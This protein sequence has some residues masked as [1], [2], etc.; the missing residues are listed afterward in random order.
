MPT[1]PSSP[2]S[3]DAWLSR[4]DTVALPIPVEQHDA[5]RRLLGDNR[6]SMREIAN[7][8]QDSAVLTLALLREANRSNASLAEPAES[9]EVALTRLG[10]Q[11]AEQVLQRLPAVKEPEIPAALRQILL[12]S[13]HASQQASGLFGA[14]LARLWQE[15]HG[16]SLLFL[17]PA[18]ALL[19]AQPEFFGRWEQ[20]VLTKGE[21]A[22]TVERELLG[23][24]LLQLCLALARRWKLPE[25][26]VEGYRALAD[27]RRM[28]VRAL[29]VAHDN[30]HPLHQQQMLDADPELRRW[31]TRPAHA[32][33]LANGLAIASHHAWDSP[34]T[35]RWQRLTGLYLQLPLEDIQQLVHQQAAQSARQLDVRG[36]WHPALSLLW[37]WDGSRLK[38]PAEQAKPPG[39]DALTLWRR[40]CS[41]LLQE[42]TAFS[43]L[44]QLA[45]RAGAA[46]E[47]CGLRR[48]LLLFIDR[49]HNRLV[50]QHSHGLPPE[51]ARLTLTP[52][53]SQVLRKL[54][55]QPGQ[56]RLA[57]DNVARYAAL[58][59]GA[60]KALF[61]GDHWLLRSLGHHDRVVMLIVADQGGAAFSGVTL[62]ALGKT[63]Q[64][65]ERA[66]ATYAG[67]AH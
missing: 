22:A 41:E 31:V 8:L 53:T 17:S 5:M 47:A 39:D 43:N 50:A 34:H 28:L 25:W 7:G 10:L 13:R 26:I 18:W 36:L 45:T 3:L 59:P 61:H 51:A 60:L 65:I 14:R 19:A 62:Q 9:L 58:L 35:L 23:V 37:P 44:P 16:G 64:C 29:H 4:L 2:R 48:A 52:G 40:H 32:A 21:P 1:P 67:R 27:E 24:P 63:A 56:L 6:R 54:L 55:A 57:P 33:L 20:R 49:T 46:L 15:I 66:L 12:I 30:A 11:R 38:R 42:P